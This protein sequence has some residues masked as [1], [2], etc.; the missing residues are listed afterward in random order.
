MQNSGNYPQRL[1]SIQYVKK[2]KNIIDIKLKHYL[3]PMV[4]GD[5][6]EID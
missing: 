4:K 1:T 5:H 6:P 3:P 2:F